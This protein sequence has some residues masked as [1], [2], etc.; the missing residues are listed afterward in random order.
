MKEKIS[1]IV[2]IYNIERYVETCIESIMKQTYNNL[3]IIL[4]DDGS[5][6]KSGEICDFY[7][8]KDSRIIVVHKLNG[9]LVSARKAGLKAATAD[10][11]AYVD[12]DDWIEPE[13]YEIMSEEMER[14]NADIVVCAHKE[15]FMNEITVVSNIIPAGV[16]RGEELVKNVYPTML[17]TGT[18][19]DWGLSPS[20]WDKLY[21]REVLYDNQMQVD[22]KIW[23]GE[24]SACVYSAI[25]DSE[26][27]C[28]INESPYHYRKRENS[29]SSAHDEYYFERFNALYKNMFSRMK[30]SEYWYLIEPQFN[31]HMLKFLNQGIGQELGIDLYTIFHSYL[32]F[33]YGS[34]KQGSNIVLYGAGEIGQIY[35]K[36]IMETG[37]C[38]IALWVD[39]NYLSYKKNN[40]NV[41][42]PDKL[43][44][45]SWEYIVIATRTKIVADDIKNSLTDR[46]IDESLI[47]WK[48]PVEIKN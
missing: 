33:P 16:Y 28:I 23:N 2:P 47:I 37:F 1:V 44:E 17:Y 40:F 15:E 35:H 21:K 6:D 41:D 39:K 18:Y 10:Y 46:G 4:V 43:E 27:V 30:R 20:C 3:E 42:T 14:N 8:E 11:I 12:G 7:K 36:Q 31:Y 24:D 29:V 45:V 5:T 9:G 38:N 22:E 19:F 13:M 25:L 32:L 26:C 34:V 48:K